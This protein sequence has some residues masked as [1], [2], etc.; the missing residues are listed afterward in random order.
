MNKI[1]AA[2]EGAASRNKA[3]T[4]KIIDRSEEP[5]RELTP[6]EIEEQEETLEEIRE[7]IQRERNV[8]DI[9]VAATVITET[10]VAPPKTEDEPEL[11]IIG[12]KR[13]SIEDIKIEE[14]RF[15]TSFADRLSHLTKKPR[16]PRE[17]FDEIASRNIGLADK[18]EIL[19]NNFFPGMDEIA[20]LPASQREELFQNIKRALAEAQGAEMLGSGKDL[21]KKIQEIEQKYTDSTLKLLEYLKL[22]KVEI[23]KDERRR[24]QRGIKYAPDV[25]MRLENYPEIK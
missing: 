7:E 23:F 5:T 15:M 6:Q 18:I 14:E 11:G 24:K 13:P 25:K 12:S 22:G 21:G 10:D 19:L 1:K 2:Q 17:Q 8:S 4:K 3:E 16:M 20:I 9:G